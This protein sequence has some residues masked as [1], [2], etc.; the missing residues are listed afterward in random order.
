MLKQRD[1][2]YDGKIHQTVHGRIRQWGLGSLF[3]VLLCAQVGWAEQVL[4]SL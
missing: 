3:V 2:Q 4:H 1:S